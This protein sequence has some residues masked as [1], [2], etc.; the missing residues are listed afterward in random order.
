MAA[1]P[2][3]AEDALPAQAAKPRQAE[4]QGE[5][6]TETNGTTVSSPSSAPETVCDTLAAAATRHELPAD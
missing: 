6:R 3:L 2:A 4:I 1:A 5:T